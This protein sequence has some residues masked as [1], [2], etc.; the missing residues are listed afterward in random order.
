MARCT[1]DPQSPF[2]PMTNREE[3]VMTEYDENI[4]LEI[5]STEA[6]PECTGL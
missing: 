6:R 2:E 5:T 1:F 3:L 4:P